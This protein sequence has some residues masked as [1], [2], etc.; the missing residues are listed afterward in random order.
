MCVVVGGQAAGIVLP[1]TGL[2][3]V[4][5]DKANQPVVELGPRPRVA[6]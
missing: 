6:V 3:V 2:A 1:V 4:G 5:H